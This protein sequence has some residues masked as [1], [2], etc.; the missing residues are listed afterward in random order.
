MSLI[1]VDLYHVLKRVP[2]I[3]DEE[4]MKAATADESINSRLT[5]IEK[6]LHLIK[7]M[8]GSMYVFIFAIFWMI[9]NLSTK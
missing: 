6:E 3:S 5:N 2:N 9:W 4:A 8:I 1:N 7:W